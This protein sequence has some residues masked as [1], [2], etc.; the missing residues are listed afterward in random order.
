MADRPPSWIGDAAV[1]VLATLGT[2]GAL[3]FDRPRTA[4]LVY[5]LGVLLVGARYGLYR[6]IS[7]ALVASFIYNFFLSEPVFRL[8]ASSVDELVPLLAFNLC[9]IISGGLAG[10]LNDRARAAPKPRMPCCS[11]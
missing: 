9:A 10:R 8:G 11:S 2:Y 6:G 4:V 5:L 1:L 3:V 7:A